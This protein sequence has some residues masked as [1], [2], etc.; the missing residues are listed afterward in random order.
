MKEIFHCKICGYIAD[1]RHINCILTHLQDKHGITKGPRNKPFNNDFVEYVQNNFKNPL[2]ACGCG[3]KTSL[4]NRKLKYNLFSENCVNKGRFNNPACAEFYIFRGEKDVDVILEKISTIQ[5]KPMSS[6]RRSH[7][8][9]IM[10]G[11]SNPASFKSIIKRLGSKSAAK[12]YL[13]D[14]ARCGVNNP[15]YGKKH[16]EETKKI[17]AIASSRCPRI[18]SL[19]VKLYEILED[20]NINYFREDVDTEKCMVDYWVFDCA[21][22]LESKI[23]LVECQGDYW[24]NKP[25]VIERDKRKKEHVDNND[26]YDIMYLWE[27]EFKDQDGLRK[28][29]L[30]EIEKHK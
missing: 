11:D 15:F 26:G 27:K 16:T 30:N 18:S 22:P 6:N 5:K 25:E 2:C 19:Q 4:H 7:M 24:H 1:N 14:H 13:E 23:L 17:C 28:K 20:L 3:K 10:S 12:K 9:K 29:I 8:S 21:I